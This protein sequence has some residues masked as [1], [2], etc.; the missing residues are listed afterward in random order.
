ME[1]IKADFIQRMIWRIIKIVFNTRTLNLKSES[2]L[3]KVFSRQKKYR[4][5]KIKDKNRK[6]AKMQ[7]N[8]LYSCLRE[9]I[10]ITFYPRLISGGVWQV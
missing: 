3:L 5:Q 10:I 1:S 8:F 7:G 2:I 6:G 9:K 4:M